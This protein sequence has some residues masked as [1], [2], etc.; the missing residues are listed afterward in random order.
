MLT[1]SVR[2]KYGAKKNLYCAAGW[3]KRVYA[4]ANGRIVITE[5]LGSLGRLGCDSRDSFK[6]PVTRQSFLKLRKQGMPPPIVV[7]RSG[8]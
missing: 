2:T 6:R 1:F 5:N 7:P 8:E 3:V 4:T